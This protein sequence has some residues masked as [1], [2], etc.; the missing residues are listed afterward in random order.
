MIWIATLCLLC[1]AA[2]FFLN[3]LNEKRWVEAHS[4]DDTVAGDPG[5]FP[6]LSNLAEKARTDGPSSIVDDN[7]RLG[8]AVAKVQEKSAKAGEKLENIAQKAR[9][10]AD[11]DTLFG[12]SVEKVKQQSEKVESK[13]KTQLDKQRERVAHGGSVLDEDSVLGRTAAKVMKKSDEMGGKIRAKVN[14]KMPEGARSIVE[15]GGFV[16][17]AVEK[18]GKGINKIDEKIDTKLLGVKVDNPEE[19]RGLR[20]DD[21]L[22]SRMSKKIGEKVNNIDEKIVA[23]SKKMTGNK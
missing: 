23:G 10:R 14:E 22:L 18:V 16:A 17:R 21:D 1:V 8:K 7:S 13:L 9:E 5:L 6:S 2:W 4:H 3:G 12:R 11:D 19:K 15:E 20:D